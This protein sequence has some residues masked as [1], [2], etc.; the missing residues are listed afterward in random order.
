MEMHRFSQIFLNGYKQSSLTIKT[1]FEGRKSLSEGSNLNLKKKKIRFVK[2]KQLSKQFNGSHI[3][4]K[5][6]FASFNIGHQT[7]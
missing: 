1:V 3:D 2:L 5:D 4:K 6:R 7:H